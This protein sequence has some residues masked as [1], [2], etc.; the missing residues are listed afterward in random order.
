[1]IETHFLSFIK[2]MHLFQSIFY[3]FFIDIL[4][5]RKGKDFVCLFLTLRKISTLIT[6]V[7]SGILQVQRNWVVNTTFNFLGS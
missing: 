1:M 4:M 3:L 6:Q 7:F 2:F 5:S